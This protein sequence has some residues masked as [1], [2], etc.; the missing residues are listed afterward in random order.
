MDEQT[1]EAKVSSFASRSLIDSS[2][3]HLHSFFSVLSF[4]GVLAQAAPRKNNKRKLESSGKS[5][6][7]LL[8][9]QKEMF[10]KAKLKMVQ[11]INQMPQA[12]GGT[13]P[14]HL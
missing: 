4:L 8:N 12:A 7:E 14:A 2:I 3:L 1:A 9:K 13:G 6:D 11:K 5:M 10:E